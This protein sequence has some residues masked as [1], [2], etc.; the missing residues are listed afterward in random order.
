[1]NYL[2]L[3]NSARTEC[4]S[5]GAPITGLTGWNAETTRIAKWINDSWVEVQSAKEDWEFMRS[6]FQ[7][8]LTAQKQSYTPT[9]AGVVSTF[10]NWKRDSFRASSP[11]ANYADEQPMNFMEYTTFRNLY[12]YA[13]MRTTYARPVVVSIAPPGK[14]LAFGSIPDQAY[15]ITGEMYTKP[16]K[17]VTA[18]DEPIIPD[19][20]HMLIVYKAMMKY[21]AFEAAP[22]VYARGEKSAKYL[23][24]RLEID[25]LPTITNGP[26]LA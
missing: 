13:N 22:E 15:V 7:F 4:G 21:G 17:L 3:I 14:S 19:D 6:P 18:T 16:T 5:A 2:D 25:Q 9:E 20:F 1:M 10:K 24:Q 8:S 26:P 12:Q 11:G 23:M